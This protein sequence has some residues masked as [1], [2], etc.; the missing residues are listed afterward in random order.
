MNAQHST[1]QATYPTRA[2]YISLALLFS[3]VVRCSLSGIYWCSVVIASVSELKAA[4][5]FHRAELVSLSLLGT[6][7]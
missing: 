4:R 7:E 1:A 2:H 6:H 3:T 5:I